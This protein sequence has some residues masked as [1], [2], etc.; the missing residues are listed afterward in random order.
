[1]SKNVLRVSFGVAFLC[2][3]SVV[4]AANYS[5]QNTEEIPKTEPQKVAVVKETPAVKGKVVTKK[6]QK[7]TTEKNEEVGQYIESSYEAN[8]GSM[9]IDARYLLLTDKRPRV[10]QA[11]FN[12]MIG[13]IREF[14]GLY[15]VKSVKVLYP[16]GTPEIHVKAMSKFMGS[17]FGVKVENAESVDPNEFKVVLLSQ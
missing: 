2:G 11:N 17:Y 6:I 5:S 1:M 7:A 13:H 9:G 16:Q 15:A 12:K 8:S 10:S 14:Q 3:W 4:L